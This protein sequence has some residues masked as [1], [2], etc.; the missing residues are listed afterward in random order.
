MHKPSLCIHIS[1]L[2]FTI[3]MTQPFAQAS[4]QIP[5]PPQKQPIALVGG[6]I[7]TLEQDAIENGVLLF[8]QGKITAIGTD[9][10]IPNDAQQID[11]AGKHIYP[12][13]FAVNTK[14]GLVEIDAVDM[15]RDFRESGRF[16]PNLRVEAAFNPDSELIPVARANGIALSHVVP[17]VYSGNAR[18]S[19]RT[20]IMYLDG[21]TWED[22]MIAPGGLAIDWSNLG[23]NPENRDDSRQN[24]SDRLDELNQFFDQAEAY[25]EAHHE[26][27]SDIRLEAMQPVINGELPVI[28][29]ANRIHNI[30]SA[31]QFALDRD[32]EIII[33]GGR[34]AWRIPDL[35]AEHEIPVI[36]EDIHTLSMRGWESY[37]TPFT[38][39]NKL[40]DA[41][42]LF[43][44]GFSEW[45]GHGSHMN[46]RNLPYEAATAV[47]YGL[48]HEEALKAITRY[49]AEIFGLEDR[50]GTLAQGKDATLIVCDGDPLEITTQVE[51]MFIEGRDIDLSSRHTML[52][53]K[54]RK[55]YQQ[56]EG[57]R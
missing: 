30:R 18:I 33:S 11:A 14:L 34:D 24:R 15:S 19:G 52:Y 5:A 45:S 54:Y 31:V 55:K 48:P 43:C 26:S 4:D 37:D 35:L 13:L 7:H 38:L 16:N 51:R 10:T 56:L 21:W 49:P 32:V 29:H 41:G 23:I 47:A 40:H 36:V 2:L 8:D 27:P 50:L 17:A 46:T 12:G 44:I 42:I 6:T 53:D 57:S 22:M 28:I 3:L 39:P 25:A 1:L 20:A 9:V